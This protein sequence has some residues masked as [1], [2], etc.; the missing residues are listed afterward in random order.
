MLRRSARRLLMIFAAIRITKIGGPVVCHAHIFANCEREPNTEGYA[1]RDASGL[2]KT[3]FLLSRKPI[4][5][6]S[7]GSVAASCPANAAFSK[8]NCVLTLRRQ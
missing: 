8:S 6:A 7:S 1:F 3:A 4:S 5:A 2:A